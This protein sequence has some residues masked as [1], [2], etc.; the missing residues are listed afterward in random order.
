MFLLFWLHFWWSIWVP[1]G[2]FRGLLCFRCL[3]LSGALGS[4]HVTSSETYDESVSYIIT[5]N[6]TT[7]TFVYYTSSNP[8]LCG[9]TLLL[10][11]RRYTRIHL[12]PTAQHTSHPRISHLCS[13][14]STSCPIF[15]KTCSAT[16]SSSLQI[17]Q[18]I[19]ST[20]A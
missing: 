11:R 5:R 8:F 16:V 13:S 20:A 7:N 14:K 10:H 9:P 6:M 19:T 2:G 4:L 18:L 15:F 1:S 3:L 17:N 12:Q